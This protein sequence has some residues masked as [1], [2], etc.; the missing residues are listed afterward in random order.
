MPVVE[1]RLPLIVN[2]R[3][4]SRT[5]RTR[6]PSPRRA[7]VNIVISGGTEANLRRAAAQGKE[8][9]GD[10]RQHARDAVT[11][12]QLPRLHL[13]AC[14]RAGEGGR[15]VRLLVAATTRTCGCCR[16]RRRCRWPGD[17]IATTRS[18]RSPSMPRRS[19]A[20]PTASAAI[21]TGKDANLFIA[22]GDPLEIRDAD[23]ARVVI[24]G[25]GRRQRQQARSSSIASTWRGSNRVKP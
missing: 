8:H 12:G 7:K 25:Q 1:R 9:P 11:R 3:A 21:E 6:S 4:A 19:S 23:H 10:P 14:R 22:N 5:S 16:T 15:E 2:G 17:S 13:P 18:A 24:K 20:S